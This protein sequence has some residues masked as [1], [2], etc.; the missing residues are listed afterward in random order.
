MCEAV[1]QSCNA[2]FAV[3]SEVR[4]ADLANL[5]HRYGLDAPAAGSTVDTLIGL[6]NGWTIAPVALARAYCRLIQ[7]PPPRT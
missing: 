7:E 4:P 3:G 5:A 1:A 2:Y 6:G